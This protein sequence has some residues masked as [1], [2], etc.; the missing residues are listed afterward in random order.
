[1]SLSAA[2]I[3]KDEADHLDA[4][5]T[6]LRGLVDEIVVVDTGSTDGTVA[7][8]QAH[9]A[10]IGHVP[11]RGDFSAPRNRSLDLATGDWILYVD[12]DERVQG[13]FAAARALLA[14]ATGT[15]AF[16]TR[17]VPRVG[18]TPFREFR[19]WR[20]R[21]DIRFEGHIH[22]SVVPAIRA[23][24]DADALTIDPFDRIT[25]HHLGY[26]GGRPDKR[27]RDEPMLVAELARNP[28]RA[29]VYDHLARVYEG[30]GDGARA[31]DMWKRGI[32][33]ARARQQTHPDDRLLYVDLIH[34]LLSSGAIDDDLNGLVSEA[35]AAFDRTP[36]LEL[37]A[38]RLAF[39]TGR[40]R[41]AL[42]PLEWLVSLDDDAIIETGASYDA[43]VFGEWSWGL[44]GLCRFALGDDAAA[45]EAFKRAE[46]SAPDDRS[47]G[48][49]RRLAEARAATAPSA[50]SAPSA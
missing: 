32:A 27:A 13:D 4:C 17:F 48:V 21:D 10:V 36:T 24:A 33:V 39:A 37:A 19:L 22:E 12:A 11:W 47:Y 38:A 15:V 30:A 1:V 43:R 34:H 9:D 46:Q 23:A 8:A 41:D 28:D 42:E 26:E 35:R 20:N 18:W 40:P 25:I 31:V 29:F 45:A 2:L 7:I 16:R 14:G 6:S 50:H 3:V 5:L 44:I 49:R